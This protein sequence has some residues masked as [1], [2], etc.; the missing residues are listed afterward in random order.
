MHV[1]VVD[2][3]ERQEVEGAVRAWTGH[4]RE[5]TDLLRGFRAPS[6]TIQPIAT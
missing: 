5:G 6:D 2:R 4:V 1:K 3:I